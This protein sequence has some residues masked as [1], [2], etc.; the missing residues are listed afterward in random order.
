[1][2]ET[3]DLRFV[4]AVA[5]APTLAAAARELDVT[6]PAVSQRLA[7][8]EAR[9][10]LR[11]V[12]RGRGQLT[13][14]ADGETL[15]RRAKT[16][17]ED[18]DCLHE[19]LAS[20]QDSVSG[21]LR[22]IAPFGFGRHYIAPIIAEMAVE[23]PDVAPDLVLSDNPYGLA[24]S[25][26]WDMIIHI[27]HLADSSL[28]QRKLASNRRFLCAAPTYLS[29]FG[30]PTQLGEISDHACG[31]IREN[32]ADVTMWSFKDPSGSRKSIRVHPKFA[33]NDGEVVKSWA[34]KGLGIVIRSEWNVAE[35]LKHSRLQRILPDYSLPDAD[36][37]A[38]LSPKTLRA[39]RVQHALEK[40][41]KALSN[42]PW[43]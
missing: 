17:L 15:A 42:P 20:Q 7:H 23:F 3:P 5:A 28:V 31:V 16:I 33:S 34:I 8:I 12:E 14:T 11:L 26:H 4:A 32:Q 10:N 41:A 27:G 24:R 35:D 9:L 13:M 43:G 1:M 37:L 25:G 2:L 30:T 39:A 29:H 38:L 19:D 21:P 40:L 6:P 36:I 18:L 22:I